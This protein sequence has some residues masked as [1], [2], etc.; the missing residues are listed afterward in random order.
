MTKG[1]KIRKKKDR[2]RKMGSSKSKE[3]PKGAEYKW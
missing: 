1:R 3:S 2:G